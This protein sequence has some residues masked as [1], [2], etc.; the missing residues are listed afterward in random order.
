MVPPPHPARKRMANSKALVLSMKS[1]FGVDYLPVIKTYHR[2][3]ANPPLRKGLLRPE[4]SGNEI[5]TPGK[6]GNFS[7]TRKNESGL[8]TF[9]ASFECHRGSIV[10]R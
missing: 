8:S 9:V 5:A 2:S 10:L 4:L 7:N 3:T 1:P 6:R